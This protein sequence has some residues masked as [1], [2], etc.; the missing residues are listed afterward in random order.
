MTADD[1]PVRHPRYAT[2][3]RTLAERGD[4]LCRRHGA[5]HVGV[6]K[7]RRAGERLGQTCITFYVERKEPVEDERRIPKTLPLIHADGP[8]ERSVATD[9]VQIGS[10]PAALSIRGGHPIIAGDGEHGTVGLVVRRGGADWLITNAHVVTDPFRAPGPV[11]VAGAAGVVIGEVTQIDD[12]DQEVIRSDAALVRMP[13]GTVAD[14][15]FRGQKLE[16]R[17]IGGIAMN[18]GHAFYFVSSDFTHKARWEGFVETK[19][20]LDMDGHPK[21]CAGFHKFRVTLG[22]LQQGDSGAV[23]FREGAGGLVAVGLLF[24]GE[25]EDRVAWVFPL[26]PVLQRFGISI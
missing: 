14:G 16:L 9:V 1:E 6:S 24:A 12:L 20:E 7:K 3:L 26:A 17:D 2:L 13:D 8:S 25:T 18:D 5:H 4:E 23:V 21:L 11:S 22:D 15:R 10:K 19:T